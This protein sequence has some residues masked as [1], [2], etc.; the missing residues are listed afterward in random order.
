M[1][2]TRGGGQWYTGLPCLTCGL[3]TTASINQQMS[4]GWPWPDCT[5]QKQAAAV[6]PHYDTQD[7]CVQPQSSSHDPGLGHSTVLLGDSRD[8]TADDTH[9]SVTF[10]PRGTTSH[11]RQSA[12]KRKVPIMASVERLGL[13]Y[14]ATSGTPTV[15][16]F[17][18]SRLTPSATVLDVPHVRHDSSNGLGHLQPIM[19]NGHQRC[20]RLPPIP[21]VG[22]QN[23]AM[24]EGWN[25]LVHPV[26]KHAWWMPQVL[27]LTTGPPNY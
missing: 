23:C 13:P 21:L 9:L 6:L 7:S 17:A 11:Q 8:H 2:A 1:P 12:T 15:D 10:C 19:D 5:L 22:Q 27:T 26:W 20:F 18:S 4:G 16:M 25:D 3:L 14:Q 24:K